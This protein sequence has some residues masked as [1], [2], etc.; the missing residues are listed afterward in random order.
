LIERTGQ[1]K[2]IVEVDQRPGIVGV[3]HDSA[4]V[5]AHD[6]H[7]IM[8]E[9]F[10][11]P[12]LSAVVLAASSKFVVGSHSHF[13]SSPIR[14]NT[15]GGGPPFSGCCGLLLRPLSAKLR[16]GQAS[17]EYTRK[18]EFLNTKNER[19]QSQPQFPPS[20]LSS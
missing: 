15:I 8:A 13:G 3:L 9:N 11:Q 2:S 5:S 10:T 7:S 17:R 4:H 12:S 20:W 6:A 14:E 18:R 19:Q 1:F 16:S